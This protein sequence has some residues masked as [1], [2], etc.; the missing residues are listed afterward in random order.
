[1]C[2]K[3]SAFEASVGNLAFLK[4]PFIFPFFLAAPFS[5]LPFLLSVSYASLQYLSLLTSL[6]LL[7]SI[8]CSLLLLSVSITARLFPSFS[9]IFFYFLL[10]CPHLYYSIL[11][12][13]L[14]FC[15]FLSFS[16]FS[17]FLFPTVQSQCCSQYRNAWLSHIV[18]CLQKKVVFW[19]QDSKFLAASS[20]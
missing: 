14:P 19:W 8:P 10:L 13:V 9:F 15:F 20:K 17:T 1:M 2:D 7:C 16:F 5:F 6:P 18:L 11:D 4:F 12:P 3:R